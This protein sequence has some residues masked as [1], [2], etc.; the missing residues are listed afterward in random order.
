MI[1]KKVKFTDR[2]R[3]IFFRD[4]GICHLCEEKI[5]LN[6]TD[7]W[8][9]T[10]DHVVPVSMGGGNVIPNLKIAH[11]WCNHARGDREISLELISE[12]KERKKIK[13]KN[14]HEHNQSRSKKTR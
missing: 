9:L 5:A 14:L 4:K 3:D 1:S 7:H 11:A 8:A 6:Q 10:L 13:L 2:V 12:I